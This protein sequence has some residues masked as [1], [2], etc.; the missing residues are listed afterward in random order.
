LYLGLAACHRLALDR[1][2]LPKNMT[3]GGMI[4]SLFIPGLAIQIRSPRFWGKIA[5]SVC[6]FLFLV[7]IVWLGYPLGNCAFSLMLSIHATGFLYYCGPDLLGR[8]LSHR[9]IFTL[10]VLTG[11]GLGFYLPIQH[12]IQTHW[13]MPLRNGNQVIIISVQGEPAPLKRGDW[14]AFTNEKGV[15][16]GRIVGLGGDQVDS[17]T[18]P[19][20][21][22]LIHTEL[23]KRYYHDAS[24]V[25][26]RSDIV[27]QLTI[28][29]REE[30]V[31]KPFRRWFW[32]KQILP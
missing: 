25:S 13:L 32:R 12:T 18:V 9:I 26:Y 5:L 16:F 11:I 1:I 17:I 27:E 4:L 21:H 3:V 24:F 29:S 7:F 19:E 10:L 31:G 23:A 6:A 8:S 22:W 2:R 15:L 30:F 20:N 14:A 28:V